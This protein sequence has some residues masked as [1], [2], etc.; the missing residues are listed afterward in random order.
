MSKG[1]RSWVQANWVDIAN[2]KKGGGFPKC[3][4][5]KWREKKKLSKVRACMLKLEPCL[6][7]K[8]LLLYQEKRKLRAEED[9]VRNL[10][11]L[12]LKSIL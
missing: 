5:S 6:Q 2:P 8:E 1:L 11:T 9:Q 10:T 4:R 3:G 12:E 7:V